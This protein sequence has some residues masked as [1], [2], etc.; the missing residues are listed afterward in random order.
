[1]KVRCV[2]LGVLLLACVALGAAAQKDKDE[3]DKDKGKEQPKAKA[4]KT[5]QEVFDAFLAALN[6]R[7]SKT[8]VGCLAPDTL[9]E[10]AGAYA[11]QGMMRRELAETGGKDGAKDDKLA[12]RWKPTFDVLDKHGLTAKATKDVKLGKTPAEHE[13]AQATLLP[14][15][16]D[17]A[18]FLVDYQDALDKDRP[19]IKDD[20]ELKAKLT[21]VKIDGDKATGA[22]VVA[23]PDKDKKDKAKEVE[24]P[25][26]FVKVGDGWKIIPNPKKKEDK[27]KGKK[28]KAA[29]DG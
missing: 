21:K 22:V 13:K 17:K 7:D 10:M 19:K 15:I 11:V 1:M 26:E 16:K 2:V 6:K 4:Y 25:V 18:A 9:K 20:E 8:F 28:D 3:K 23:F 29:K 27:D 24:E 5:P 12:K 14:L